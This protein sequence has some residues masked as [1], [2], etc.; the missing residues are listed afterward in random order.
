M[1]N[2]K[3]ES[4]EE[5]LE[6]KEHIYRLFERGDSVRDIEHRKEITR[7]ESLSYY[8]EWKKHKMGQ[9]TEGDKVSFILD[10]NGYDSR[11]VEG[12][13]YKKLTNAVIVDCQEDNYIRQNLRGRVAV[14]VK[15]I[16]KL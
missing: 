16:L 13:V 14:S 7:E 5:E 3:L 9:L 15:D 10:M 1:V 2:V 4:T 6:F 12:E 11:L 8:E